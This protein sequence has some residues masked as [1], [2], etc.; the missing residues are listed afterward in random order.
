M[1]LSQLKYQLI[2][3]SRT[4]E[5]FI[6]LIL[7]PVIM[8]II[9]KLVIGNLTAQNAFSAVPAA[10]VEH[11]EDNMFHMIMDEFSQ[12]ESP[13]VT[14]TYCKEEE[15]LQLL[16]DG[17]VDGILVIDPSDE[18]EPAFSEEESVDIIGM[19]DEYL[20]TGKIP[21]F[22]GFD[23]GTFLKDFLE[24]SD[25]EYLRTFISSYRG[26]SFIPNNK[27]SMW[28]RKSGAS[29]TT[30]K[31][32]GEMYQNMVQ[33]A[34]DI[35]QRSFTGDGGQGNDFAQAMETGDSLVTE[36]KLT[37]GNTDTLASYMYNVI[38]MVSIFGSLVGITIAF[39]GQANLSAVGARRS[40]A[41][42]KK[43]SATLA[44]LLGCYISMIFC[45]FF[46][47]IFI[48]VVL[49]VDFGDKLPFVFVGGMCGAAVGVSMGFFVGAL[50]KAGQ[51][52]KTGILMALNMLMLF[53]SGGMVPGIRETI[54]INA[55]VINELNPA[56]VI[57][58]SFYYLRMDEDLSR[59]YG[60]LL[61]MLS[62]T[63]VFTLLG[64]MLMRRKK[65]ASL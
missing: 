13:M 51:G 11:T 56:A 28:V 52:A 58:D 59:F 8:G 9:Y 35:A 37:D 3:S 30:I 54:M 41:G 31:K 21:E 19:M 45:V 47:I 63:A 60:K 53:L 16:K 61:V 24:G 23:A 22:E 48:I 43:F 50:G 5:V 65:Y 34:N 4:R 15:A 42:M 1:F 7:F 2:R 14:L 20:N 64:F 29:Q 10:V 39:E 18:E 46:S 12:G 6:W 33:A 27:I 25:Q 36:M 55:P 49:Q 40:M 57:C 17:E 38:A 62:F 32:M 26:G 44:S